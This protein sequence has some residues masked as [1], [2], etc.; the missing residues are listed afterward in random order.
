MAPGT[1]TASAPLPGIRSCPWA[2]SASGVRSEPDLPL[3]S[4]PTS[5]WSLA[6]QRMANM[7]P[8]MP[9]MWGSVRFSTA[10][11]ATAA[12]TALPPICRISSPAVLASGWLVAIAASG[13]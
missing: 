3:A 1:V 13:A 12:S 9:V 4:R 11:A 2:R 7:S 6:D 8:P 10:A 5:S